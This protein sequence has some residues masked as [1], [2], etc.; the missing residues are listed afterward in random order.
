MRPSAAAS[1]STARCSF[2]VMSWL[3]SAVVMSVA[4]SRRSI[5]RVRTAA[6][7]RS[8]S[9]VTR[10]AVLSA[11]ILVEDGSDVP[12][13]T[14]TRLNVSLIVFLLFKI[15]VQNE[16]PAQLLEL[17]ELGR[18]EP[19]EHRP[20][21]RAAV[22]APDAPLNGQAFLG[23]RQ[24]EAATVTWV[25]RPADEPAVGQPVDHP[26]EGRLTE[27]D[28]TVELAESN[29]VGARG[30]RGEDVVL[31]HGEVLPDV[32]RVELPRQRRVGGEERLPRVIGD[33]PVISHRG[34]PRT[35][36]GTRP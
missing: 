6:P 7:R 30:Q 34:I 5:T 35:L 28:V 11:S 13:L 17:A 10:C 1:A 27:Q 18:A 3:V 32:L 2:G 24:P 15:L 20:R 12:A 33:V 23:Q 26:G 14:T 36:T 22:A 4:S 31:L 25:G 9:A 29:G 8:A 16:L 21:D 19:G